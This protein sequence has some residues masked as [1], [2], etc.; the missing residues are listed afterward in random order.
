M[1]GVNVALAVEQLNHVGRE[2]CRIGALLVAAPA[3]DVVCSTP[4]VPC[5][6]VAPQLSAQVICS[7]LMNLLATMAGS[8]SSAEENERPANCSQL[9]ILY[10]C[11]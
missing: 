8:I 6:I 4:A 7:I 11:A 10:G 3:Q 1:R 5:T 2:A 9:P